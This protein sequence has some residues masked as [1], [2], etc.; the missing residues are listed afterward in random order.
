MKQI[1]TNRKIVNF[2]TM[3]ITILDV[4]CL[5][6]QIIRQIVRLDKKATPKCMLS[7]EIPTVNTKTQ[8]D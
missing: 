7:K 5:N 6:F 3:L 2:N 4:N 8:R 1:E